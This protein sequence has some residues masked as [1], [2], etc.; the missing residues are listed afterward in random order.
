MF[1]E[2]YGS[3]TITQT[4]KVTPKES[5]LIPNDTIRPS[6]IESSLT[7]T[8]NPNRFARNHGYLTRSVKK[9][10]HVNKTRKKS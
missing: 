6:V 7:N 2:N 1:S 4:T 5:K 10:N 3:R 8:Y 9:S